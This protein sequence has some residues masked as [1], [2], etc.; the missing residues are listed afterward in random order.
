MAQRTASTEGL[1]NKLQTKTQNKPAAAQDPASKIHGLLTKMGPELQ[2]ALPKHITADRMARIALTCIRQNPK[3]LECETASLLGSIM[4]AAQLGLEPGLLGLCYLVPYKD[5]KTGKTNAQFQIGYK[6]YIELMRRSGKI[7]SV[8]AQEVCEN[9]EFELEYGLEEKLFH[10]PCITGDRGPAM[11]YYA[12]ARFIDGGHAFVFM[13]MQEIIRIRDKY[14]KSA[15]RG[16]WRD[17]FDAM[18]KKT[19]IKQLAKYMPMS[20]ELAENLSLDETMRR[21]VLSDEII[22]VDYETGEII[23]MGEIQE[24][25]QP[26]EQAG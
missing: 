23:D 9:D 2:K 14:S 7:T 18:A 8:V 19:A 26:P 10:K 12:Y 15:D 3:L 6:G 5:N 1:T 17:E 24:Q 16:P 22:S 20:V 21:D 11:G 13:T 25:E 4:S